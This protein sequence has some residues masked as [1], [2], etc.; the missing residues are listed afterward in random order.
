MHLS[1]IIPAYNEEK[2]IRE[3]LI[4]MPGTTSE[5]IVVCDGTDET[6]AIVKTFSMDYS[7]INLRCIIYSQRLGKGR[8]IREGFGQA[9]A[10][11]L[12]IWMQMGPQ[13]SHKCRN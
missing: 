6:P 8:A 2:R 12:G 11:M 3:L 10:S 4:Q 7:D 13:Q 9:S 5:Y 1:I